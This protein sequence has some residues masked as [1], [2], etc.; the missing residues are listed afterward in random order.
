MGVEVK[1]AATVTSSDFRGLRGMAEAAGARF[2]RG[3]VLYTG[4]QVIPFGERLHAV[5]V[6]LLWH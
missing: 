6:S 3:F 2:V 5:P 4:R 1:A